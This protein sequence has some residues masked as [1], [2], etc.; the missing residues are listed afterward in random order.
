MNFLLYRK[1]RSC[2]AKNRLCRFFRGVRSSAAPFLYNH[3]ISNTIRYP[4][5]MPGHKRNPDFFMENPYSFDVTEVEGFDDLYHPEGIL[6]KAMEQA[7]NAYH[8]RQTFYL[9]GGST[10][11]ILAAISACVN[12]GDTIIMARNC[13][14]SVYNTAFLLNLN[15]KYIFPKMIESIDVAKGIT[16]R[17][18][19][20]A[21]RKAPDAKCVVITSP[22][23]EGVVSEI[24][25]ISTFLHEKGIPLIVDEAH[26]AHLRWHHSFPKSALEQGADVVVQS[27][28]KTLPALTQTA[29]LHSN[30]DRISIKKIQHY[31]SIYQTSSPSYVLMASIDQCITWLQENGKSSF[32]RYVKQSNLFYDRMK[33][34]C[35]LKLLDV[36]EKDR[37]K[38]VVVTDGTNITGYE[39][40][41]IL[42]NKYQIEVEMEQPTYIIALTSIADEKEMF[43]RFGKILLEIDESLSKSRKESVNF[44]KIDFTKK[45]E[46]R[47]T[48]YEASLLNGESL[49][50]EESENRVSKEFIYL[51]PPGIP[52][53]VPGEVLSSK[54]IQTLINARKAGIIMRGLCDEKGDTI[55]VIR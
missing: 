28:H 19:E 17:D 33:Q 42:R 4:L 16:K 13:H 41:N 46:I 14:K 20:E 52:F 53:V 12:H 23:Y 11:G 45:L 47:Y 6:K 34:L 5:H 24:T 27:L 39:L 44:S 1:V 21:W 15:T 31:L 22:T 51:Y 2:E 35:R 49:Q 25:E 32:S 55:E 7:A 54:I 38:I 37:T 30:S 50:I 36:S 18:V 29:L 9:V 26:G 43:E 48:S 40:A 8:A 10:C 3:L